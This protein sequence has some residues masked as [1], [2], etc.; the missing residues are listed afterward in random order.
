MS[1]SGSFFTGLFACF[2]LSFGTAVLAP[3]YQIGGL[4][5][6]FKEEDGVISDVYPN[7]VS[8]NAAN[9]R[10][11]YI[12]E[13]C[14]AC[15]SQV[16]RGSESADIDRGWGVRR[17]VARDY[18]FEEPPVIG[19]T[20]L[21][22]DLTNV[23]SEKWRNEPELDKVRPAKR[24]SAWQYLH[25][26]HPTAVVKGSNMPSYKHLFERRKISGHPSSDALA[27]GDHLAPEPGFEIVP[28]A[29]A[30]ALIA[31]LSSL[32]RSSPLKEAG[33]IAAAPPSKK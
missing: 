17:T 12:A 4:L 15:H 24:D 9:G 5:P 6:S 22:P 25:L 11:V 20:R 13:G 19:A 23:G 32:N 29:D 28:S 10:R 7:A 31:Y 3:H 21:G 18:I 26:Y 33:A 27:L 2:A 8:G 30:K 14:Q 1:R 16:V